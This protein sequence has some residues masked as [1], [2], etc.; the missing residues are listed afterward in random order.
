MIHFVNG[1]LTR[2]AVGDHAQPGSSL[3]FWH[4]LAERAGHDQPLATDTWQID[5]LTLNVGVRFDRYR[6]W[7]PAQTIPV[8]RFNP[9][10]LTF[11]EIANVVS[12]NH[13]V[14]RVGATYDVKGDAK[15]VLKPTGDASTSNPGVNLADAINRTP[16]SA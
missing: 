5:K 10:A 16:Q 7:L 1:D 2:P 6:V 3:Y 14:P 9:V 13:I 4:Q 12:F 11:P 8:A 15:T